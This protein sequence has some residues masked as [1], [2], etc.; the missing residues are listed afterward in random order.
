VG[1]IAQ[2]ERLRTGRKGTKSDGFHQ[3]LIFFGLTSQYYACLSDLVTI[4]QPKN[5]SNDDNDDDRFTT[6][7]S[8]FAV[9]M[10]IKQMLINSSWSF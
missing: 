6:R 7:R 8:R 9:F 2:W 5:N 3:M 1:K 4:D 10:C